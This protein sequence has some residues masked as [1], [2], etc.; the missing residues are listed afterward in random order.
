MKV[1]LKQD[2]ENLGAE[3]EI[4]TVKAGYG[5]NYLIPQGLAAMATAGSIKAQQE[6]RRQ[7]SRKRAQEKEGAERVK[8]QLENTEVL[9]VAKVGE[10]NRIFGTVTAQQLA[11]RLSDQGF[12]IDRRTI[13]LDEEIRVI[14]VY[15]ATIKLHPEVKARLTVRVEPDPSA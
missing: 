14:G 3:G 10:E 11:V 1:I 5:R 6:V 15:A 2:V 12:H 8:E 7:Q 4:V 9:V 13:E